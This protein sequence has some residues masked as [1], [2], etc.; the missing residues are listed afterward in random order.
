MAKNPC[1]VKLIQ[2]FVLVMDIYEGAFSGWVV[3]CF[4]LGYTVRM[5]E[6]TVR[7]F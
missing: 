2:C 4:L 5:F 6:F 3:T 7:T 1:D